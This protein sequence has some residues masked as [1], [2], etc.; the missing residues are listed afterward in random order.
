MD[1]TYPARATDPLDGWT[2]EVEVLLDVPVARLWA[3]L[4]DVPRLPEWSPEVIAAAWVPPASSAVPGA[5]FAATNRREDWEWSLECTVLEAVAPTR[6]AW[7]VLDPAR[8]SSRW[9]VDLTSEGERTRVRQRFVHG[10]GPSGVRWWVEQEPDELGATLE[11]RGAE[12]RRHIR[13]TL[14]GMADAS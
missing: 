12:L 13:V 10:P 2:V 14:Q 6:F 7:C 5:R 11:E 1:P 9:S 4:V 8:P 3:L